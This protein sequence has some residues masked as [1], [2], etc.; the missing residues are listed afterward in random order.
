MFRALPFGRTLAT[1]KQHNGACRHHKRDQNAFHFRSYLEPKCTLRPI[2]IEAEISVGLLKL[3]HRGG[4]WLL[5]D[6]RNVRI[7]GEVIVDGRE[8][9]CVASVAHGQLVDFLGHIC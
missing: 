1:E 6:R 7:V 2:F 3:C 8:I 5:V 9:L 4:R